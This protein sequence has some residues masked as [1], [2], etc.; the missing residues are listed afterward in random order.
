MLKLKRV[1]TCLA[2]LLFLGQLS[3]CATV[4][5][6]GEDLETAGEKVQEAADN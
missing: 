5:G 2:M 3:A 1:L 6:M 4:K